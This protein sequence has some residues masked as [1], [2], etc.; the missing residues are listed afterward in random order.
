MKN[1]ILTLIITLPLTLWGQ[2]WVQTYPNQDFWGTSVEQTNDG[3]YIITGEGSND[4][5]L[6]KVNS[7]G[8][9]EWY[10][11]FENFT[12][13]SIKKTNDGGFII[14]GNYHN[15]SDIIEFDYRTNMILKV[16]DLGY[17][18]WS[19]VGHPDLCSS[20]SEI[21][22]TQEGD[23]VGCGRCVFKLDNEGSIL[24]VSNELH[25]DCIE[26]TSDGGYMLFNHKGYG[27]IKNQEDIELRKLDS[28]G[29][30]MWSKLIDSGKSHEDGLS[31]GIVVEND[32]YVV[33]GM[34][35]NSDRLI[36]FKTDNLG[37][38]IWDKTDD[39]E[40]NNCWGC[41]GV[42]QLQQTT[43]G[44]YI[45]VFTQQYIDG[46]HGKITLLKTDNNGNEQWSQTYNYYSSD[47]VSVKQTSD[48]GFVI[49]GNNFNQGGENVLLIKTNSFGN[50]TSTIEI[51][52]PNPDRKLEKTVNLKG[53]EIKPQTNQPIIEIFDDGSVEKKIIV[54]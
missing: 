24:W 43:D 22:V 54:E 11:N 8:E 42:T 48:G 6:L 32:E 26:E 30:L 20:V 44:G 19:H 31:T 45:L 46:E 18:E 2:G 37:N 47:F 16:N 5:L 21:H 34:D 9:E 23:Y 35:I 7:S 41:E 13:Y 28:N 17:E 4:M 36:F 40:G 29:N 50:I 15:Q 53:Q 14:V 52:L 33:F 3:G 27:N 1:L 39:Y 38:I 51:P 10:R 12:G 25:C 49:L